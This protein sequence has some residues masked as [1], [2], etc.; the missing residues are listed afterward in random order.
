MVVD[1]SYGYLFVR[2]YICLSVPLCISLALDGRWKERGIRGGGVVRRRGRRRRRR[3]DGRVLFNEMD[4]MITCAKRNPQSDPVSIPTPF[5][6]CP[7]CQPE[8]NRFGLLMQVS[9]T[10]CSPE[11]VLIS[12][13]SSPLPTSSFAVLRN[14]RILPPFSS[15]NPLPR[16]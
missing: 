11:V 7:Q 3:R 9:S 15:L 6:C 12:I 14:V 5:S 13:F 16:Y 1:F 8:E 10:P 2:S 4:T